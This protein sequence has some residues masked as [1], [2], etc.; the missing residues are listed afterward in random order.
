MEPGHGEGR[1]W[2]MLAMVVTLEVSKLSGLL[3]ALAFCRVETRAY[4][5]RGGPG[6]GRACGAEAAQAAYTGRA[7]LKA[8]S[9]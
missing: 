3:N 5:A 9:T 2:N 7:Q 8:E 1:T 4:D 6:G